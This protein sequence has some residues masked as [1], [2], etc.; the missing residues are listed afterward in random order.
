MLTIADSILQKATSQEAVEPALFLDVWAEKGAESRIDTQSQWVAADD[1]MVGSDSNVSFTRRPGSAT[2][3]EG[4]AVS[5]VIPTWTLGELQMKWQVKVT[6]IW[7]RRYGPFGGYK[8]KYWKREIT[9]ADNAMAYPFTANATYILNEVALSINNS[10]NLSLPVLVYILDDTGTQVG[11]KVTITPPKSA[12]G[13]DVVISGLSA[14]ILRGRDYR[15]VIS[16]QPP[17]LKSLIGSKKSVRTYTFLF[18]VHPYLGV[19]NKTW[20]IP[21]GSGHVSTGGYEGYQSSGVLTRQFDMGV[22][23]T[24]EG[25]FSVSD[26]VP[27]GTSLTMTA[28]YTDNDVIATETNNTNWT[29]YGAIESGEVIPAHRYWRIQFDLTANSANDLAPE[30]AEARITYRADPVTFSTH[31]SQVVTVKKGYTYPWTYPL[32]ASSVSKV[33]SSGV[34]AL[35]SA[36]QASSQLVPK[37]QA[38]MVGRMTCSLLSVDE[39]DALLAVPLRG[40]EARLRVGYADITDTLTIYRGVCTDLQYSSLRYTLSIED[41]LNLAS[42]KVPREKHGPAWSSATTYSIGDKVVYGTHG[43]TSL[44]N[45]NTGNTPV[46][47]GDS[48]WRDEG[49]VWADIIYDSTTSGGGDWHLA[50]IAKDILINHINLPSERIDFESLAKVKTALPNRTGSRIITKPTS[51]LKML[52][53]L[54]WL[55]EAQWTINGTQ[56]SLQSE[57]LATDEPV[58][59]IT[60]NDVKEG[61]Q[62]RRGFSDLNNICLILTGYS[63]DG[64]GEEQFNDGEVVADATSIAEYDVA[65]IETFKDK[66]NVPVTEL[67][68]RAT[69]FVNRFKDGRRVVSF[70]AGMRLLRLTN[71]DVVMFESAQLPAGDPGRF[72]MMVIRKDLDWARQELKFTLMEV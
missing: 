37:V 23:P 13:S 26:I 67:Q 70:T 40:R 45:S 72:K 54:A 17:A 56:L 43:Y 27:L 53:E 62:Y 41:D 55:L 12:F 64:E 5:S 28:F 58:E 25:S 15:L 21:V 57:P 52:E 50:D 33:E 47:G 63:G 22:I 7:K 46:I 9:V 68:T 19:V 4:V 36:S 2:L 30:V 16:Y 49:T 61:L 32:L 34:T 60:G 11:S 71:G 38:G 42:V 29:S 14:S 66:W 24:G 8:H 18:N 20:R 35:V 51:A 44:Q 31:A 6:D 69:N 10:G 39:V 48:W 1:P 59:S 3:A 65:S